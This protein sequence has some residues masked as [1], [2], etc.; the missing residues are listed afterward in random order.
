MASDNVRREPRQA[1]TR[2]FISLPP[3]SERSKINLFIIIIIIMTGYI[4]DQAIVQTR[5]AEVKSRD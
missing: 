4:E 1:A 5:R 3:F 2:C